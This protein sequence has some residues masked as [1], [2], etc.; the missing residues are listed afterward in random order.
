[1]MGRVDTAA[2]AGVASVTTMGGAQPISS[3]GGLH[4][5]PAAVVRADLAATNGLVHVIDAVLLVPPA[6]PAP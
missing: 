3:D 6:P 1:M 5:G 2:L 4:V